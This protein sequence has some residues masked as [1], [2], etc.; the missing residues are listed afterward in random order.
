MPEV[1]LKRYIVVLLRWSWLIVISTALAA[2]TSYRITSRLPATYVASETIMVGQPPTDPNI[3]AD[4][5]QTIQRLTQAYVDMA[6]RE[7]VLDGVV[8]EL[9]LPYSWLTLNNQVLV[10]GDG[11]QFIDIRVVDTNPQRAKAIAESVGRQ[12]VDQSP[13]AENELQV[14]Q[15]QAFVQQQLNSLQTQIQD[16]QKS[17]D[18]KQAQLDQETSARTVLQLQDEIKALDDKIASWQTTYA[19]LLTTHDARSPNTLTVLEPATVPT[20]P[21][22]PSLRSNLALAATAGF[23]LAVFAILIIEYFNDVLASAEQ[24]AR[25][26]TLP[27]LG[28][29]ARMPKFRK[30]KG[31]DPLPPV[32]T[33]RDPY[34][35]ISESYRILRTN[36]QL[37]SGDGPVALMVTSPGVREGKSTT[38][39]NLAISFAQAGKRTI[40]VD[41]DLRNPSIHS[42]L[43][44]SND[45]GLTSLLA[46]PSPAPTSS[47]GGSAVDDLK[48]RLEQSLRST[49]VPELEVLAAGPA[50]AANPGELLES[51]KMEAL[52][53]IM[54][55][56]ADV[57]VVDS[58]PVNSVADAM[59]LA[60][61]GLGVIL[62][63]R[64]G[65]TRM[66]A[67][68]L[69]EEILLQ[70]QARLIG[71][72]LNAAPKAGVPY[73]RRSAG[74][75]SIP[76]EATRAA[77]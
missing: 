11:L 59:I 15:R 71:I 24:V 48:R 41:A 30:V 70:A 25:L 26:T 74:P 44:V 53:K 2:A 8:K 12:L 62:V 66:K 77:G 49:R 58:P 69:A 14:Q 4:Q 47:E 46:D 20:T 27:G 7:P 54:R 32:I 28:S 45:V 61:K 22:G 43:G 1:D 72:V 60:A 38:S 13:T 65:K 21:T 16:A 75:G 67:A 37:H 17:R 73:Y 40:L 35:P 3:T 18:A 57:I 39:V 63:I 50:V 52:L 9:Q 64:L 36:V 29:I 19:S 56:M 42:L 34:S 23:L 10:I 76:G 33:I 6:K 51:L 5:L 31:G 55:G 68:G